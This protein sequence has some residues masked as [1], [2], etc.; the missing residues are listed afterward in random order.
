VIPQVWRDL[1][2]HADGAKR[3]LAMLV[4][5]AAIGGLAEAAALL[6][7]LRVALALGTDGLSSHVDLPLANIS[8]SADQAIGVAALCA[9]ASLLAHLAIAWES[10]ALSST[11]LANSRAGAVR[12]YVNAGWSTQALQREG[13][14]QEAISNLCMKT[15][16]LTQSLAVGAAHLVTLAT[17]IAAALVVEPLATA[18]VVGAGVVIVMLMRPIT[19]M[20]HRRAERFVEVNTF[21]SEEVSRLTSASMELKVFGVERAAERELDELN[22]EA[23]GRLYRSRFITEFAANLLKD[24]AVL[25]LV[26]CVGVLTL[27]DRS[28]VG[29]IGVVIALVVRSLASAQGANACYHMIVESAPNLTALNHYLATLEAGEAVTGSDRLADLAR[30]EFRDVEYRYT[31]DTAALSE[32]SLTIESGEAIG[33]LGPSGGG[34]STLMQVLLRLRPPSAGEVLVNG[35]D[36]LSFDEQSWAGMLAFVPQEPTLL[37]ASIAENIRYFRPIG[38]DEIERAARDANVLDDILRL[39]NGFET[40]LGP[41]GSGLSGGQKQRVAIARAL[42]GRPQLLVMDEPSSALD[43]RSEELLFDAITRLKGHTTMVIVA[44]R[45][46]TVSSCDRLVVLEHGRIAELGTADELF[47]SDGFYRDIQSSISEM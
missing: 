19:K 35:A 16:V 31:P 26:G 17:F 13:A 10:A 22:T 7:A 23:R 37:E 33:V 39:P 29:G 40:I 12:R 42:V 24:M 6:L 30:I 2:A 3:W 5:T 25:L 4:G 45:L 8:L 1:Q 38:R 18:G 44:H 41:R 14:L 11:V 43:I 47:S 21:F 46:K 34:K 20:A 36:Y 28:A 27:M 32:I 9:A 15:S